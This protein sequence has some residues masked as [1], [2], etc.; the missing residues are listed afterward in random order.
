MKVRCMAKMLYIRKSRSRRVR[1]LSE[2]R[3]GYRN[4]GPVRLRA[5][6]TS[7]YHSEQQVKWIYGHSTLSPYIHKTLL[8]YHLYFRGRSDRCNTSRSK[9]LPS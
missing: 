9:T 6:R 8:S 3:V 4:F 7:A 1:S 5:K 2:G